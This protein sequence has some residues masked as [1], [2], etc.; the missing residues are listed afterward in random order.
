[1]KRLVALLRLAGVA[2]LAGCTH[3]M[4]PPTT[5]FA[6]YGEQPKIALRVALNITPELRA[7][8][9]E[10]KAMGDTWL[11]PMGDSLATNSEALARQ[12]F[13]QVLVPTEPASAADVDAVITPQLAYINRTSGATSFGESIVAI[14]VEWNLS[15]RAGRPVW[16]ETIGGQ[17]SGSSGWTQPEKVI[18][19]AL[20]DMLTNSQHAFTT[21][22][23]VRDYALRVKASQ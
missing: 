4:S 6:G 3:V 7:A 18:K 8:K 19:A 1:M 14:K 13:A 11:I 12:V 5:T 17:S 22:P 15:D 21:A 2:L 23:A 10:R 16:L 9:W 20:E